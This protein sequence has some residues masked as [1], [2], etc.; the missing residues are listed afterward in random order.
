M[1]MNKIEEHARGIIEEIGEDPNRE[2]LTATPRRIAR[3]YKN[4]LYRYRK[5]LKVMEEKERNSKEVEAN[6]KIIPV[7]VFNN[8]QYQ[9][10]LVREIHGISYCE[11]HMV[12]FYFTAYVAIIPDKKI[13]GMNKID[14]IVKYFGASLQIQERLT[15]EI[16]EFI[17]KAISPKGVAVYIEGVHFCAE[18]QGD[19]GAFTT[20]CLLGEF[21]IPKKGNPM[22]EFLGVIDNMKKGVHLR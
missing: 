17:D 8:D 10:M 2:G 13:L 21:L 19:S 12:P 20:N 11:H 4:T 22:E 18:L 7:T 15:K 6:D 1:D 5:E 9:E 16:A 3:L 14:K